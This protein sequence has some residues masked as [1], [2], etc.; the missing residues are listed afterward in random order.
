MVVV[1]GFIYL[2]L[3]DCELI[4][5]A[6]IVLF[7]LVLEPFGTNPVARYGSISVALFI[8][9]PNYHHSWEPFI[10]PLPKRGSQ[11]LNAKIGF[12]H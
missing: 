9:E 6:I 4:K 10:K 8:S 5:L 3:W 1:R 2:S 7:L 12:R 11:N